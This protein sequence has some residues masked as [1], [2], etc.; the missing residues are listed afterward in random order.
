M[1]KNDPFRYFYC[2]KCKLSWKSEEF[3]TEGDNRTAL[4]PACE[5][6]APECSHSTFNLANTAWNNATGPRTEEG[7]A[8]VALNGWKTGA[9][10]TRIRL[11]A[12]AKFEKFPWC[13]DCEQRTACKN[14][15]IRYC[16]RD[17]ETLAKFIQAFKDG[18]PNTLREEAGIANAQ[19]WKVFSMMMHNIVQKG[20]ML[21]VERTDGEGNITITYEKNQLIK[22]LPS[23]IGSLGFNADAQVMTPKSVEQKE[24]LEGHLSRE[25][26]TQEE[27]VEIRKR[28]LNEIEKFRRLL[29]ENKNEQQDPD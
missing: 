19:M 16:P 11:M 28:T 29:E 18:D 8:R 26:K 14:K 7:K 23:F 20:V 17:I 21:K 9:H 25:E 15:E 4:C 2:R 10:C 3:I 1:A 12:P 24:A 5:K 13:Q 27:A 22:E 6:P